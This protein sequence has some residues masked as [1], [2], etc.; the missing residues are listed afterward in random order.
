MNVKIIDGTTEAFFNRGKDIAHLADA[1]KTIPESFMIS[2]E[3]PKDFSK[4]VS[5]ARLAL[6]ASVRKE[7]ASLTDLA[8]KLHRDRSAVKRDISLL[9]TFGL[10]SIMER[11]NPGHGKIKE[12]S[13]TS[14]KILFSF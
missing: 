14:E 3:D 8:K 2:F 6:I 1:G 12:V 4:I 7:S 10:V 5:P 11:N 13:A 9:E